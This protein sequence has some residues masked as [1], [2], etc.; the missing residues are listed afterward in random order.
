MIIKDSQFLAHVVKEEITLD[1]LT[2][3][4][5]LWI[6]TILQVYL[7]GDLRHLNN[8]ELSNLLN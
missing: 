1:I 6:Q 2:F 4:Q 7:Y 8:N 3:G 5:Q